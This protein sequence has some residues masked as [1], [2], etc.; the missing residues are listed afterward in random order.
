MQTML[1]R[2]PLLLPSALAL[3]LAGGCGGSTPA[4]PPGCATGIEG[5]MLIDEAYC[6]PLAE[7]LCAGAAEC[8][9]TVLTGW[10]DEIRECE[11]RVL[12]RCMTSTI[13]LQG[14]LMDGTAA[15]CE[16]AATRCIAAIDELSGPCELVP[17]TP[18][19][20]NVCEAMVVGLEPLGSACTGAR[21]AAGAGVC[22]RG[23]CRVVPVQGE[24]CGPGQR[25]AAGLLCGAGGL[26]AAPA[27]EG[28]A[29]ESGDAPAC[30]PPLRCRQGTCAAPRP[31][32]ETCADPADCQAGLTCDAAG[33]CAAPPAM[34]TGRMDDCGYQGACLAQIERA[35]VPQAD[36][37]QA[38]E[39]SQQCG[40][41]G[42]CMDNACAP[43]PGEGTACGDGVYCA[44]GLAC[45]VSTGLCAPIPGLGEECALGELGPLVCAD[46]LG[47]ADGLCGPLPGVDQECV[48]QN[49]CA[50]GLGCDFLPTG[51]ICSQ[52]SGAGGACT[53]DSMCTS[54][55]YCDVGSLICTPYEAAGAECTDGNECGP[56]HTCMLEAGSA[57][58]VD[59]PGEG[60]SC[61]LE[62]ADGLL[63]ETV[64]EQGA[65]APP[66]CT[67]LAI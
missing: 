24:A 29:C 2:A 7:L 4:I 67:I 15:A 16:D 42:Y 8:S 53:N 30:L 61:F 5:L 26:C 39:R 48:G 57:T 58:C 40:A 28:A 21:C 1:S 27:G 10:P 33:Q 18:L 6:L 64:S 56:G 43:L 60:E 35:C 65:C 50:E 63:C 22:D 32:G 54:G 14:G 37:G 49:Q 38:C 59:P 34:C 23:V 55:L 12:E 66:A 13:S 9:C 45:S 47:C 17:D 44:A 25:C 51:S 11:L 31:A 62:C 19:L 46:G 20:G 3:V 36:L 52:P 41:Q